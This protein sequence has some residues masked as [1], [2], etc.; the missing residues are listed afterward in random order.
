MITSNKHIICT[1][2]YGDHLQLFNITSKYINRY[3]Q[4]VNS[5]CINFGNKSIYNDTDDTV[6]SQIECFNYANKYDKVLYIDSDVYIKPTVNLFDFINDNQILSTS[7]KYFTAFFLLGF[8]KSHYN[9]YNEFDS[10]SHIKLCNDCKY[11]I[12]YRKDC[13]RYNKK[14]I[15][16]GKVLPFHEECALTVIINK[17]KHNRFYYKNT[18]NLVLAESNCY[19]RKE[20]YAIG[21]QSILSFLRNVNKYR[22]FDVVHV[23]GYRN[24]HKYMNDDNA[25]RVYE[26]IFN[27]LDNIDTIEYE[28]ELF[29]IYFP[30]LSYNKTINRTYNYV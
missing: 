15:G 8:T 13:Y 7:P 29:N 1:T 24:I 21:K 14:A 4:Y 27:I 25:L 9:I 26:L 17:L 11:C 30:T 19:D 23:M 16:F 2:A 6:W 18:T 12:P 3:A 20:S 28:K 5:E 22:M 10:L